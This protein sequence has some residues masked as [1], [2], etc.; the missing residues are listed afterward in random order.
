MYIATIEGKQIP[1]EFKQDEAELKNDA[2][3]DDVERDGK[4]CC[5]DDHYYG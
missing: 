4:L 3:Y 1:T 2:L 5:K